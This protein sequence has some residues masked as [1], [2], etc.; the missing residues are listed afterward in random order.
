METAIDGRRRPRSRRRSPPARGAGRS[1]RGAGDPCGRQ[2]SFRNRGRGDAHELRRS[3]R[4]SA[5]PSPAPDPVLVCGHRGEPAEQPHG[6]QSP[7]AEHVAPSTT[8]PAAPVAPSIVCPSWPP[9]VGGDGARPGGVGEGGV[10]GGSGS[11]GLGGSAGPGA[12]APGGETEPPPSPSSPPPGTGSSAGAGPPA[13]RSAGLSV[14]PV[15]VGLRRPARAG[16]PSPASRVMTQ[17]ERG[18]RA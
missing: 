11:V 12:V 10:G 8:C 4:A 15:V 13:G 17:A 9:S 18:V 5:L 6:R 16:Q 14:P 1:S 3:A 7:A 2:A